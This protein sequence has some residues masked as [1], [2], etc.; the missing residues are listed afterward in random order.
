MEVNVAAP[1]EEVK[2]ETLA[3]PKEN[4]TTIDLSG[5][6]FGKVFEGVVHDFVKSKSGFISDEV[7]GLVTKHTKTMKEYLHCEIQKLRPVLIS[8]DKQKPVQIKGRLHKSFKELLEIIQIERQAFISGAAGTGKT[9]LAEQCAKAMKLPFYHISCSAGMSEAHLLGRMLFDGKYVASD[10]VTCYE[11]GGLFL[12][13]EIDAADANT[14]LVINSAL[15]NGVISIPN[16]TAKPKGIRHKDC[17][18][19]CS[20]NTWGFGSYEYHGRN[21]LD[22]AFLDRFAVSKIEVDYDRELEQEILSKHKEI[23]SRLHLLRDQIIKH[24]I[25]RVLSTRVF[26]SAAKQLAAG[27]D[28]AEIMGRYLLGWS[29]EEINKVLEK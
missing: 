1:V 19:I 21:H 11:K 3:E 12:L 13:D 5:I 18:I 22:A 16:R 28:E 6:D 2:K 20:A 14:M 17:I 26:V 24:K 29:K 25:K 9:T 7:K 15:A 10:F 27:K 4:E 8:I 23:C